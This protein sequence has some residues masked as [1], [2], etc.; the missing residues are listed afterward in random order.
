MFFKNKHN[1]RRLHGHHYEGRKIKVAIAGN[2]NAGKTTIFNFLTGQ[3]QKIGNY[4]GVTVEKKS[5]HIIHGRHELE[6]IFQALTV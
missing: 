1:Q 5:G 6:L 4:P 2:P 3:N